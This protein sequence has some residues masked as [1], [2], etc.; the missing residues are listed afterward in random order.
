MI[1]DYNAA[2][3]QIHIH[4]NGD[5]AID[6]ALDAFEKALSVHYRPNHRHTLQHCQ[7]ADRAHFKRM[8]QL[9][10]GVN[11]FSNHIYFWGDAHVSATMGPDRANRLDDAGG[12]LQA[13]V[14]L[15]IHSDAPVTMMSP[16]FTAWCAVNRITSSGHRLGGDMECITVREALETIT[17]GA[18]YSL[19]M[20]HEIGSIEVGKRADFAILDQDPLSEGEEKLKDIRVHGTLVGGII[21]LNDMGA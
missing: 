6:A 15:A 13:G 17:L 5:G 1:H 10:L 19:K 21:F 12:A 7:M 20:D 14:P 16:L 2:G 8:S 11:L 9:G 4:T 18:A 3:I